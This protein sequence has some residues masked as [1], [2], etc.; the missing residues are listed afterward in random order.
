MLSNCFTVLQERQ[1]DG[2]FRLCLVCFGEDRAD[3]RGV[4]L[5]LAGV[6]FTVE[7]GTDRRLVDVPGERGPESRVSE[8]VLL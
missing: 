3:D 1:T 2:G 6:L 7:G 5:V 8:S 4:V